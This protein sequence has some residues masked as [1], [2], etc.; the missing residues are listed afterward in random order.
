LP[1]RRCAWYNLVS[2]KDETPTRIKDDPTMAR[3]A[4]PSTHKPPESFTATLRLGGD[5]YTFRLFTRSLRLG[6]YGTVQYYWMDSSQFRCGH[7]KESAGNFR[8][9]ID[10]WAAAMRHMGLG[11]DLEQQVHHVLAVCYGL[12]GRCK[13]LQ[14]VY[15]DAYLAPNSVR[16]DT[17]SLPDDVRQRI[18]QVVRSRDR[19]RV[20]QELDAVLGR[21]E[22]PAEEMPRLQEACRHWVGE[23]VCRLR[24]HGEDGLQ[25]FLR[26]LDCWLA[27]FRKR[28]DRWL[29]HFINLF[30]YEYKVAFFTCYANA[31]VG[32][33]PWLRANRGLDSFSERFL[34]CWH[35]QNQPVDLPYGQAPGGILYPNRQGVLVAEADDKGGWTSRRLSLQTEQIGPTHVRDV[36]S[37]QVLSLHPLSGFVMK[38]PA[39]C[40]IAG[41]FFASAE[42]GLALERGHAALCD[43][44]W[45]FVG[46]ILSAARLYRQELDR[47][48]QTRHCHQRGGAEEAARREATGASDALLLEDFAAAQQFHCLAC[49]GPLQL[50]RYQ[51]VGPSAES[52]PAEFTC[53]SCGRSTCLCIDRS[54][55]E[56]WLLLAD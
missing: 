16:A 29:R 5:N 19:F 39:L 56:C 15:R 4:T 43:A 34:R 37:G 7:T 20:Q 21:F 13:S 33:I 22:P 41:R 12:R 42:D 36:F 51:P 48:A 55:L 46:A 17:A 54:D 47:Q 52:F 3:T 31:W 27:K 49:G 32:L 6:E 44:Y 24:Q 14:S 8:S 2:D 30:A 9:V 25:R 38:D 40:A 45:D 11:Q 23:G 10:F 26:D 28:S 18:Q 50:L 53:R 1:P 35:N